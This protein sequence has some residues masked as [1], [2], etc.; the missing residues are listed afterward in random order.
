MRK[1]WSRGGRWE[2]RERKTTKGH[3][4]GRVD[5]DYDDYAPTR[6]EYETAVVSSDSKP[7]IP[8]AFQP[9]Y[10]VSPLRLRG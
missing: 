7:E 4:P 8:F 6:S 5:N 2:G 1:R 9:R 3:C 10:V